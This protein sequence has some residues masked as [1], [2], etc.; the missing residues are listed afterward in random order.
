VFPSRFVSARAAARRFLEKV[1]ESFRVAVVAFA[2]RAQVAAPAT[3]DRDVT[4]AALGELRLGEGTALGEAIQLS[5]RAARRVPTGGGEPAP[6]S[7]LLLSDGAQTVGNVTPAAAAQRARMQGVPI[8]TIA[9]GTDNGVV[10]R[11][12]PGGFTERV[13]VPPDPRTLQ[14]IA[15]TTRGEFFAAPT[16]EDL[17]KVYEELGSRLGRQPKEAE[18]TVAFAGASVV[19]LLLGG[20]LSAL[21]FRR[22]P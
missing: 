19:L 22:L 2:D 17:N 15:Q 4:N 10:E 20:A 9:L 21:L 11:Q 13:R 1:P 3:D 7:I 5:L 8:N 16:D 6:A 14:Q 12:L 18:V